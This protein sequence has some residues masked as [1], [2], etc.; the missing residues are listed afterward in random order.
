M[1]QQYQFSTTEN[2]KTNIF[3]LT[4]VRGKLYR[5]IY[6]CFFAIKI[7]LHSLFFFTLKSFSLLR[8]LTRFPL[9]IPHSAVLYLLLLVML[10]SNCK[11]RQ[12]CGMTS[13]NRTGKNSNGDL[14]QF[15]IKS[16][17]ANIP[18]ITI[19]KV[20]LFFSCRLTYK[21][22]ELFFCILFFRILWL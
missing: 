19:K 3:L 18:Y 21:L 16:V 15:A 7:Y 9:I 1:R 11:I 14:S 13:L 10:I 5:P 22:P 20:L 17:S 4:H 2:S 12:C 8:S 6:N